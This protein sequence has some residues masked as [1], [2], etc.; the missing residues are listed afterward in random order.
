MQDN[1]KMQKAQKRMNVFFE[2]IG[3]EQ[4]KRDEEEREKRRKME[5]AAS[6]SGDGQLA[7]QG[8]QQL[9]LQGGQGAEKRKPDLSEG[10]NSEPPQ[11]GPKMEDPKGTKRGPEDMENEEEMNVE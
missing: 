1:P 11:K 5:G 3:E 6:G 4:D 10:G 9:A 2:K 8:G 7:L